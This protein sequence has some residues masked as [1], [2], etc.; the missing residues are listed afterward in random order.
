M[1]ILYKKT[2]S[3]AILSLNR[4]ETRNA[5]TL[6]MAEDICLTLKDASNDPAISVIIIRGEGGVFSAGGDIKEMA[7]GKLAS[8]DMKKLPVGPCTENPP[9]S[10][11]NRQA[12][13]RLD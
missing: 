7:R 9:A 2:A 1:N 11:R 3:V 5:F 13:N 12:G 8:W 4:P 6:K 10:R